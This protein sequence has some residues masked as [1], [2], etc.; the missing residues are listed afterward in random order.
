MSLDEKDT[1]VEGNTARN[2]S[3]TNILYKIKTS[4]Y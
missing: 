1:I 4:D 2:F 3:V